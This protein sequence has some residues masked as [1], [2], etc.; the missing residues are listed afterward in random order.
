MRAGITAV[1]LA[2]ALEQRAFGRAAAKTALVVGTLLTLINHPAILRLEIAPPVLL[3]CL[4]N[5]MVPFLVAGYSRHSLLRCVA[6][7]TDRS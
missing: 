2:M 5:Y 6:T 1:P 3:Q 7:E 4:L